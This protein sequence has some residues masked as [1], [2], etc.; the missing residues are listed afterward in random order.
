MTSA[1]FWELIA[2]L[3]GIPDEQRVRR[4]TDELAAGDPAR[5][6]TFADDLA[7]VVHALD[8]PAHA[9]Q[10]VRDHS[11]P[12][13]VPTIPLSPR[14]F[15]LARL[16]VVAGGRHSWERALADPAALA[17]AW[18][19]AGAAA[20]AGIAPRAWEQATG[21]DWDHEP[22]VSM[23]SGTNTSAWGNSVDLRGLPRRRWLGCGPRYDVGVDARPVYDSACALLAQA[24]S[25]DEAWTTWW[26]GTCVPDLEL[27]PVHTL[28]PARRPQLRRSSEVIRV[29]CTL[30]GR[31][32]ACTDRR[33]LAGR[34]AADVLWMLELVRQRLALPP[35]PPLPALEPVADT[36]PD[37]HCGPPDDPEEIVRSMVS[38]L[39]MSDEQARAV[40]VDADRPP[41]S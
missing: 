17:G 7:L 33:E 18:D 31:R 37:A 22:E 8:T 19:L 6:L 24:V 27:G 40:V 26:A 4:L 34:A 32:L 38:L 35:L 20:L 16:A 25:A 3:G 39:G 9:G 11:D 15:L 14:G 30:D 29:E 36:V 10:P 41:Y 28:A 21:R 23:E 1:D 12:P 5:I 13:A 2:Q